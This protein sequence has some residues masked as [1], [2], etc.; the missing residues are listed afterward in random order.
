M[1]TDWNK[2][3]WHALGKEGIHVISNSRVQYTEE[4][5]SRK[6]CHIF[7]QDKCYACYTCKEQK[8]EL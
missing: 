6:K 5:F 2:D 1:F 4:D 8:Q 7:S 3:T